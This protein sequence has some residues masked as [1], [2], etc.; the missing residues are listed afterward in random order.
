MKGAD[1]GRAQLARPGN[2]RLHCVA[3]EEGQR[4]SALHVLQE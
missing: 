1:Q 3:G 4:E 2:A